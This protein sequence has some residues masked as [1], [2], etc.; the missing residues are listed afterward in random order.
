M[1]KKTKEIIVGIV[2]SVAAI[3]VVGFSA[4]AF[5]GDDEATKLNRFTGFEVGAVEA[6]GKVDSEAKTNI[7]SDMVA[8]EKLTVKVG[9]GMTYKVHYFD[10]DGEYLESTGDMTS[11][12]DENVL[13]PDGAKKA[14]VEITVTDDDDISFRERLS[15][16]KDVK[17]EY[18]K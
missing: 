11:D 5:R 9:E 15:Y 13:K 6:D 8:V 16:L 2:A 17:V 18:E 1:K 14:I 12:Y 3:F 7:V 4:A 10:E